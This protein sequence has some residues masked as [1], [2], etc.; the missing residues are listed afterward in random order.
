MA[1]GELV[2]PEFNPVAGLRIGT[3]SAGIKK[4]GRKDLV[5]FELAAGS[6]T[7]GIFTLN[8][9]CA[10]PV[11]LCK[12]H[13]QQGSPRYL[14]INTGNANAGTGVA[15]LD[16][17]RKTC[18]VLADLAGVKSTEVLPFS[19]GVI[20][21]PL[22]MDRLLAALPQALEQLTN[23]GW[24][25]AA[26]GIMTTDTK[27]KGATASCEINGQHVVISGIAK[28]AGMIKPNMATM[29]GFIATDATIDSV[30]LKELLKQAADVSFN[31]ITIDGDTSTNDSCMLVATGQSAKISVEDTAALQSFTACLQQ[32]MQHLALSI[33]RDGEGATKFVTVQVEQ[34]ATTAEALEAAFTVAHSPLVKTALYASDANW[35]RILAAVGRAPGLESLDVSSVTVYLDDVLL[36]EQGGRAASYTEDAGSAVMQQTEITLRILLGRGKA[37]ETVWTCDFSHDYVTINADY[38]T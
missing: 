24:A 18:Q 36:V 14:V 13:L 6:T 5:V 25:D 23:N 33:V 2:L 16:N 27:P 29:L 9:F 12:E 22:P 21:E 37:T 34:A 30:L 3:A 11:Q 4:P 38:R 8:A 17:A 20:G 15:G 7:A 1:V 35:G 19:T 26:S 28:G 10:A 31:R 32:V